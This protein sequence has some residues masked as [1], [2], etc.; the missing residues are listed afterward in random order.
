MNGIKN[1]P[2]DAVEYLLKLIK[3]N[4]KMT[5]ADLFDDE[6]NKELF[7]KAALTK[8]NDDQ[9]SRN[10]DMIQNLFE[11]ADYCPDIILDEFQGEPIYACF[12]DNPGYVSDREAL[13][14]R[15]FVK[16]ELAKRQK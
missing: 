16:L 9:V 8:T 3:T 7:E 4:P 2:N 1:T 11:L 12:G 13:A 14:M 6:S 15:I 5:L 10:R